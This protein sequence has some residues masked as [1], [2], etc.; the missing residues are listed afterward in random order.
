MA[1]ILISLDGD[2]RG[3]SHR[4]LNSHSV[5]LNQIMNETNA[6]LRQTSEAIVGRY[7]CRSG[8]TVNELCCISRWQLLVRVNVPAAAGVKFP[9]HTELAWIS[10]WKSSKSKAI[11]S[12]LQGAPGSKQRGWW[13]WDTDEHSWP[14]CKEGPLTRE[15]GKKLVATEK[16]VVLHLLVKLSP[17]TPAR[18]GWLF[19]SWCQLL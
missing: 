2:R 6:Q 1:Q 16:T 7:G 10:C 9:S 17:N 3:Q 13:H 19:S 5:F 15:S 11:S 8:C 12:H 18:S 4:K 14:F